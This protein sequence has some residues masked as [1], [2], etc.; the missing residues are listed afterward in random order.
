MNHAHNSTTLMH[1]L[2]LAFAL[3]Q[4]TPPPTP[5][6]PVASP[7]AAASALPVP[8]PPPPL[9]A[10]PARVDIHP[11]E[12][13]TI[14]IA[15][16]SA[17]VSASADSTIVAVTTDGAAVTVMAS[18]T[19]TGTTTLHV[20]DAA[21]A[22]LELP[23]RVLLDAVA[24]PIPRFVGVRVTGD[25]SVGFAQAQIAAAL[26]R[27]ILARPGTTLSIA[28]P[29]MLATS[30]PS[31]TTYQTTANVVGGGAYFDSAQTVTATV[32]H[33]DAADYVPPV[34]YYDDD[35]EKVDADGVLY[36]GVIAPDRPARLYY[37]HQI[38]GP[39]RR[40]VVALSV[41]S[42]SPAQVQVI[43][44]T[45][46]PNVDVMT[47]GHAVT[48]TFLDA[49]P[50]NVGVVFDVTP[51][52]P[53]LLHDIGTPNKAV[54]AGNL[55]VRVL[56]GG[57]V[58]VTVLAASPGVDPATLVGGTRLPGDGHHRSGTFDLSPYGL[59]N[60]FFTAG[61]ADAVATYG[62]RERSPQPLDGS[63]GTDYGDYGVWHAIA[64][65]L[66][67][68]SAD[69]STAYLFFR[70]LGGVVRSSFL[71]DGALKELGCVRVSAPYELAAFQLQ[72]RST[73]RV[74]VQTMT[75]GGSNY[76]AQVGISAAAPTPSPPPVSAPEGCFPKPQGST[77]P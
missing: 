13:L 50:K 34:L 28:T 39:P 1:P 40:I 21:G 48:R 16:A 52:Q 12:H 51:A 67:N 23:V 41:T 22:T 27:T 42:P 58:S 19:Q 38:V 10:T 61:G 45:A 54:V 6:P 3:S 71:I 53:V 68:P 65:T 69:P 44:A 29:V 75:D 63:T 73:S 32:T 30:S 59:D 70:P 74:V 11:G 31:I 47:V 64:F 35:P 56:S 18:T 36:R 2:M 9:V 76:P 33:V 46:G 62:A 20:R 66:T 26:A 7:S 5:P 60:V 49:K 57:P 4:A 8:S 43:D 72:P 15:G 14:A 24:L 77:S 25:A 55:D 37:Y 17:P